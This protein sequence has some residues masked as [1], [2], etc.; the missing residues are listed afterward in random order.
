MLNN[1]YCRSRICKFLTTSCL[2]LFA[3][4]AIWA[5]ST[6]W[7]MAQRLSPASGI[8]GESNQDLLPKSCVEKPQNFDFEPKSGILEDVNQTFHKDYNQLID[9]ICYTFGNTKGPTVL[10]LTSKNLIL[11]QNGKR[12]EHEYIP[13]IY[14]QLKAIEHHPLALYLTLQHNEGRELTDDLRKF[15]RERSS[16]LK[17]ALENITGENWQ[18]DVVANQQSLLKDSIEYID[19]VLGEGRID[20][21]KLNNYVRKVSP[22]IVGG[23]NSAATEQLNLLNNK[24]KNLIPDI[25]FLDYVVIS[26]VH[27]A[28]HGEVVTQYFEHVFNEFQGDAAEREDRI[29]YA[30]SIFDETAALRLLAA[31]ILDREIGSAFFRNPR[32]LQRDALMDAASFWL[33]Q[34]T[35]E[36]P[37]L[38]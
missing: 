11:Y 18:E 31:H 29:V 35:M 36:I 21:D 23:I 32:R 19:Q 26:G 25:N 6:S 30:E 28:R 3:A 17:E 10:L 16:L 37:K 33:W 13:P 7:V 22:K 9:G 38:P 5:G 8:A 15:L 14:H 12:E 1:E 20:S 34:H 2:V 24:I 27:Q 4:I